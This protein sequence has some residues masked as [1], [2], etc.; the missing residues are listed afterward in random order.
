M[1]FI[2]LAKNSL[3]CD[4]TYTDTVLTDS[5]R[6]DVVGE[7]AFSDCPWLESVNLSGQVKI[8]QQYVFSGTRMLYRIQLP[9]NL[10]EVGMGAFS[11]SKVRSLIFPDSVVKFGDLAIYNTDNPP[12]TCFA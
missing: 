4:P 9:E 10:V 1:F 5:N 3:S 6:C 11:R 8:L 12:D 7:R 2:C